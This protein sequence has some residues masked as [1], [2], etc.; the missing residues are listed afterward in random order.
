MTNYRVRENNER[1]SIMWE[2]ILRSSVDDFFFSRANKGSGEFA[3]AA[4]D[5]WK[6]DLFGSTFDGRFL[7]PKGYKS[8]SVYTKKAFAYPILS[9][10]TKMPDMSGADEGSNRS[11]YIGV[12]N[13]SNTGTGALAFKHKRDAAN[14]DHVYCV[15]NTTWNVSTASAQ[16]DIVNIIDANYKTTNHAWTIKVGR[17]MALFYF[18]T[19]IV[20]IIVF[21]NGL[22]YNTGVTTAQN[23]Y[24]IAVM[25]AQFGQIQNA[26]MEHLRDNVASVDIVSACAPFYFRASDGDPE[27][28][29]HLP[30]YEE[31][32]SNKFAGKNIAAGSLT[33]HPFPLLGF[34]QKTIQM[35]ADQA[36]TLEIHTMTQTGTWRILKSQAVVANTF[37]AVNISEAVT[38][39][40]VKFTPNAY[41]CAVSEGSVLA[42]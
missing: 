27:I 21:S 35:N 14:V 24:G 10:K 41:P 34:T 3:A 1:H 15:A 16:L 40:R 28:S 33:S 20:C 18:D 25:P 11:F 37:L 7:C 42:S 29:L 32:T 2:A 6:Q 30:L 13:G 4:S 19:M 12:E 31:N 22:A 9:V 38:L 17:H 36:G 23:P 26:F 5:I 39:A 8:C